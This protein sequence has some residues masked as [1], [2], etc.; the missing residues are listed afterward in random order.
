QN[1]TEGLNL[2][3][4]GML[5]LG[6][7]VLC[8]PMEHN[9]VMRVLKE[10]EAQGM[11]A[12]TVLPMD[13]MGLVQPHVLQKAITPR[14]ALVVVCHASNVIGVVQPVEKLGAVCRENGV[15]LLVDATQTAGIQRVGLESL[16]AD[17]IAMPGHKGL[18][19]PQG[20]GALVM[21]KGLFPRPLRFG[22]TGSRSESMLQPYEMP[23]RYESGTLN[24]PGIAGLLA[25]IRFIQRHG[26]AIR[27]YEEA[28]TQR[29]LCALAAVSGV[30]ILGHPDAPRVGVVS[31]LLPNMDSSE[32]ADELDRLGFALRGGLHCAPA[33]H[34]ALGTLRCGAVRASVGIYNT[35]EDVDQLADA[36]ARL[37]RL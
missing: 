26:E 10:Y 16:Q 7:E 35:E 6:D 14:T 13:D 31:F 15:P 25:G 2:A 11:I 9:A 34:Q 3:I 33:A 12:V 23:D 1:G 21:R 4:R 22:G 17:M 32:A 8:T 28:L 18:L 20:T 37:S 27:A 24:L 36:V 29:L 5:H 30:T 19:G